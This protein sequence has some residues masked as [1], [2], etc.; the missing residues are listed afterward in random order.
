MILPVKLGKPQKSTQKIFDQDD[1]DEDMDEVF[2]IAHDAAMLQTVAEGLV[3][4]DQT[5]DVAPWQ[6]KHDHEVQGRAN[7]QVTWQMRR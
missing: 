6:R 7:R 2:P 4:G 3:K 1:D 5:F